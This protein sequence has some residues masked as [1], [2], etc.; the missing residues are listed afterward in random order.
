MTTSADSPSISAASFVTGTPHGASSPRHQVA[1]V[2]PRF[3]RIGI[4]RADDFNGLLF[5][6]QPH[7]RR[8]DRADA[9]LDG[10]NFLFHN[11]LRRYV[12]MVLAGVPG[13][14]LRDD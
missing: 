13:G 4:D 12:F 6:H 11:G 1:K 9:V 14:D 5:P 8:T 3:R 10:A 7:D 2:L